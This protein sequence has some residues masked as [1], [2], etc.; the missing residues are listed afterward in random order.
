MDTSKRIIFG[1][2]DT[3]AAILISMAEFYVQLIPILN[4]LYDYPSR[5]WELDETDPA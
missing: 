2:H 3:S 4:S 1:G 5:H